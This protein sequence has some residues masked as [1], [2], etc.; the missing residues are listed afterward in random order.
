MHNYSKRVHALKTSLWSFM[1][2]VLLTSTSYGIVI[3]HDKDDQQY[4]ALAEQYLDSVVFLSIGCVGTLIAPDWVITANHCV[5]HGGFLVVKHN[6]END[7]SDS[8]ISHPHKDMALI[9]LSEPVPDSKP[10]L[11]YP[12]DDEVGKNVVFVGNGDFG[13]GVEGIIK[14]DGIIRAATNT[15]IKASDSNISFKFNKPPK[16][17]EL[18]GISGPGDSGGPAFVEDDSKLY[19]AGISSYQS[20]DGDVEGVY[21]VKEYYTRVSNSIPWINKVLRDTKISEKPDSPLLHAINDGSLQTLKNELDKAPSW[22]D[23]P[24]LVKT[25]ITLT[26]VK[27]KPL[28]GELL[29]ENGVDFSNININGLPMLHVVLELQKLDYFNML[30]KHDIDFTKN[31]NQGRSSLSKLVFAYDELDSFSLLVKEMLAQGLDI[32]DQDKQ[33][34]S[35]MH[36]AGFTGN[37]EIFKIL[38]SNGAEIDIANENGHTPL[39]DA[40]WLGN[41]DILEYLLD[42]GADPLLKDN[43]GLNALK[44]AKRFDQAEAATFLKLHM[45]ENQ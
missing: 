4:Q 23:D 7:I 43:D 30:L 18:E 39:M 8:V 5:E 11:L 22:K 40:A 33:G 27:D 24:E 28:M 44:I 14:G 20:G 3:R 35:A 13:N 2:F 9:H 21:N 29:I 41:I 37:L 38:V 36:A 31:D 34:E 16:G 17:T 12:L 10:A 32:N 1:I 6:D 25:A 26:I 15:I 42:Q 19:I 45:K